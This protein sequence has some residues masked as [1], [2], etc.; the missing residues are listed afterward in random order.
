MTGISNGNGRTRPLFFELIK[1]SQRLPTTASVFFLIL[2]IFLFSF[3]GAKLPLEA[4]FLFF[5]GGNPFKTGELWRL[6]TPVLFHVSMLH[7]VSN[8]IGWWIFGG[9]IESQHGSRVLLT[10][11]LYIAI[12]SNLFQAWLGSN[13]FAG[14]SG[15]IFGLFGYM[16]IYSHL[17]P[18][19]GLR[20]PKPIVWLA[21]INLIIGF[22][23]GSE[24]L[25]GKMANES[26]LG[27][28]LVGAL[29]GW[30]R[31]CADNQEQ[32]VLKKQEE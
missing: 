31:A 14:L 22:V 5:T 29:L 18:G 1:V 25:I 12:L 3:F 11:S 17:R 26:H 23:P 4:K 13:S 10:L 16:L 7:L 27:G 24:L 19:S 8:S 32:R 21:F 2:I 6:I 9:L 28:F 30:N 15:V 20:L